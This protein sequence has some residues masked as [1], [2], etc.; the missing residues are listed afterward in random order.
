MAPFPGFFL[1]DEDGVIV[2]TL[3]N[4]HFAHLDGVEAILDSYAGRVSPGA[5]DPLTTASED[6]GITVTAG[7][8]LALAVAGPRRPDRRHARGATSRR[9]C[10]GRDGRHLDHSID[11][12]NGFR[13]AAECRADA[14][15]RAPRR[16]SAA[17]HLGRHR[18]RHDE[19]WAD[20]VL[21]KTIAD[22]AESIEVDVTIRYQACDNAQCFIPRTQTLR[23]EIP[24]IS[25]FDLCLGRWSATWSTWIQ[26]RT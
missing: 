24:T 20:S 4:R 15:I 5:S 12:P 2:D 13:N 21:G 22:G 14:S 16:F 8:V 26:P 23:L 3:F 1:L 17:R 6:D 9:P 18:R 25:D 11:G 7:A 19:R 10:P